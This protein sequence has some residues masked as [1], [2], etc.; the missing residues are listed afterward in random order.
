MLLT[1][2]NWVIGVVEFCGSIVF[3]FGEVVLLLDTKNRR[4][5]DGDL[6]E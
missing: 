4:T 3:T 6:F 1:F 5:R 2:V